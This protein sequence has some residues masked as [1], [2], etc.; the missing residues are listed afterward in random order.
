M[1]VAKKAR[2]EPDGPVVVLVC[3][4]D[5]VKVRFPIADAR[6][7]TTIANDLDDC[8]CRKSWCCTVK[9]WNLG[10]FTTFHP[11]FA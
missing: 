4:G 8:E 2:T 3:D 9:V 11:S 1:N 10:V 5:G 6:Q 7:S